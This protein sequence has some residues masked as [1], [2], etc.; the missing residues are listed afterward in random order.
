MKREK[1]E[2]ILKTEGKIDYWVKIDIEEHPMF[3]YYYSQLGVR[4]LNGEAYVERF[5]HDDNELQFYEKYKEK[6]F[7]KF[8]AYKKDH[9]KWD[10]K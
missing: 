5:P 1:L 8:G 10:V 7:K 3:G 9:E 4:L 2:T 6:L